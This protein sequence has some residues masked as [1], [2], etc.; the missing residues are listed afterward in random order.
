[1]ATKKGQPLD[2]SALL[3]EAGA[4]LARSTVAPNML[5]YKPHHKQMI[6]HSS[7]YYGRLYIGGNR[8]GKTFGAVME[9]IWWLTGTHPYRKTPSP[10]IRGRVVGVDFINGIEKILLP[11]FKQLIAPSYLLGGSWDSAYSK[12]ERVLTFANN[13]TVEFMSYDQDTDKFAGTSRH[14]IH[15]DEEPPKHVFDECQMRIADTEGEF[16]VSMTPVDGMTWI[17]DMIYDAVQNADDLEIVEAPGPAHGQVMCSPELEYM[18]IE[19]DQEENP[20][21]SEKG[22]KRALSTLSDED[23]EARKAGKFVEMSGLVYK[24]FDKKVHVIPPFIP[25]HDWE[26]YSSTDHGWNNPT[27]T[28]WHA[29]APNGDVFTFSEHYKS[30]MTVAEHATAMHAREGAWGRVPDVRTGDPAMKQTQ[31]VTGTSILTEY[32][33]NGIYISVETV[34]RDVMT[35]VD[36]IQQYLRVNPVTHKPKWFITENCV[37]LIKEIQRLRWKK[38]A[39]K[40]MQAENN[41]SEQIQ[42]K[43]DHAC[44]SARYFFTFM[45]E[46]TLEEVDDPFFPPDQPRVDMDYGMALLRAITEGK[47]MP[48]DMN[49]ENEWEI[50][51]GIDLAD[52]YGYA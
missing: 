40:K 8:S 41:K 46:L 18:I 34:P 47:E 29:V 5:M 52:K 7:C 13:S 43:D 1:M 27:A 21:L 15:Y 2:I 25:P 36:R 24:S 44:D 38:Y 4:T 11:L 3:R 14:F 39:S 50:T 20:Y 32:A 23:R 10:P 28:L 19:V 35:G 30:G 42:K 16:W 45:P 6:F 33:K 37:N 12:S 22:R 49:D 9:D 48:S 31:A 26:W 17:F 51:E